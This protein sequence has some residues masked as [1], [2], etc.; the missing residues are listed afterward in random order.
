VVVDTAGCGCNSHLD[1][2]TRRTRRGAVRGETRAPIKRSPVRTTAGDC[3]RSYAS[4][5]SFAKEQSAFVCVS[6]FGAWYVAATA[7]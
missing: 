7:I 3:I 4:N 6:A 5:N 1:V 2:N